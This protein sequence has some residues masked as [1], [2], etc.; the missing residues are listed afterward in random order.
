M[1]LGPWA[2]RR[3]QLQINHQ[4]GQMKATSPVVLDS[5]SFNS[6]LTKVISVTGACCPL[7]AG[8]LRV[9]FDKVKLDTIAKVNYSICQV[10]LKA[11]C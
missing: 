3:A 10:L 4:D 11:H 5:P 1:A 9:L 8:M 7:C 6:E 2:S